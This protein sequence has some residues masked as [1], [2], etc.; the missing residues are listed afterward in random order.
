[1]NTGG[2]TAPLLYPLVDKIYILPPFTSTEKW[3]IKKYN[4]NISSIIGRGKMIL[5]GCYG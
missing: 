1:M 2:R 3:T 4:E 5:R